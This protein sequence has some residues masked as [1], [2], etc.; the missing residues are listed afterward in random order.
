MSPFPQPPFLLPRAFWGEGGT[1]V[2]P[3]MFQSVITS[4]R[5]CGCC[6]CGAWVL[7]GIQSFTHVQLFATP[8]DCSLSGFSV[9]GI[10]QAGI[11]KWVAIF[12][13]QGIFPTQGTW[14]FLNKDQKHRL[15]FWGGVKGS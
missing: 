15:E 10:L 12:F 11:L 1:L 13:L 7:G 4:T 9:R 6:N 5:N 2:P 8:M 3:H 14:D